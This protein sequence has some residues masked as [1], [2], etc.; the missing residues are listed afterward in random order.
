MIVGATQLRNLQAHDVMLPRESVRFLSA[1]MQREEVVEFMRR[2]GHSQFPFSP[3]HG[4]DDVSGVVQA[5]DLLY[6]LLKHDD[7]EIDWDALR[8]DVLVV[9]ESVALAQ[10][11]KTYQEA[12]RHLAIVVDEYGTVEGIATLEDVL[13]EIVGDIRDESD[14]PATEFF[15]R[16]DGRLIVDVRVDL[17][18]LCSRLGIPLEPHEDAT[19]VRE[20]V[21]ETLERIPKAGDSIEWNGY[22]IDVLRADNRRA[23]LVSVRR[24]EHGG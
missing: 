19:T 21:T 6:W 14:S 11:L 17:R 7:P 23:R 24:D 16:A 4:L 1:D 5:K 12:R 2:T 10:L 9:P 15:E 18:K 3:T 13:E 20:L 22:R 8:Q